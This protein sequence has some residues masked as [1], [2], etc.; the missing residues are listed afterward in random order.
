ME[1]IPNE[2]NSI[3]PYSTLDI[4]RALN[5]PRERFRDWL[6]R[7][8]IK[9]TIPSAGRGKS[10]RFTRHD[11][12]KIAFFRKIVDAGISRELASKM[13]KTVG[14]V[15]F[16]PGILFFVGLSDREKMQVRCY[17]SSNDFKMVFKEDTISIQPVIGNLENSTKVE[18][19]DDGSCNE[20]PATL[21]DYTESFEDI[22]D[23]YII[24]FCNIKKQVDR[25]LAQM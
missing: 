11:I 25:A 20:R 12:Y 24:N 18:E 22:D 6:D 7:G 8:F 16:I 10:A 2:I 17:P 23:V 21:E 5:I 19:S 3:A 1:G 15:L 13:V 4:V 9:P 14:D